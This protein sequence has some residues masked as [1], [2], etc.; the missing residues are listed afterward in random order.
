[1]VALK[2]GW[3]WSCES[4]MISQETRFT[5]CDGDSEIMLIGQLSFTFGWLRTNGIGNGGHVVCSQGS[6]VGIDNGYTQ[7]NLAYD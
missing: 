2:S 7:G 6:L 1:M 5:Q 3:N 4:G